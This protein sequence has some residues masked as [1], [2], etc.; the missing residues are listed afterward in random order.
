MGLLRAA[1]VV[2]QRARSNDASTDARVLHG[3]YEAGSAGQLEA[4]QPFSHTP[5]TASFAGCCRWDESLEGNANK[6][7]KVLTLVDM[8]DRDNAPSLR[9]LPI[10]TVPQAADQTD[11]AQ[12][13]FYVMARDQYVPGSATPKAISG[14][15]SNYELD[16][17]MNANLIYSV[18]SASNMGLTSSVYTPFSK[19]QIVSSSTG[20]VRVE[21][22]SSVTGPLPTGYYQVAVLVRSGTS[23]TL[24]DFM[25]HVV[26]LAGLPAAASMSGA[27][28]H[29][30]ES[31]YASTFG[32]VGYPVAASLVVANPDAGDLVLN[33]VFAGLS[34]EATSVQSGGVEYSAVEL[35]HQGLP[36]GASLYT[37]AAGAIVDMLITYD[38][39]STAH[40]PGHDA[41]VNK[42]KRD[43]TFAMG[44]EEAW[45]AGYRPVLKQG[46]S[47]DD[48]NVNAIPDTISHA[49][50][51]MNAGTG[52]AAMYLWLKKS[53]DMPAITEVR[54]A[55][56]P[57]EVT[58]YTNEGFTMLPQNLNEQ[59]SSPSKVYLFYK[60]GSG[61]A[62]TDITLI[63]VQV[64][65]AGFCAGASVTETVCDVEM[66][67]KAM[68]G[69]KHL[70]PGNLNFPLAQ[71]P[72]LMYVEVAPQGSLKRMLSWVP[73]SAGHY[74]FCYSG[75]VVGSPTRAS[76]QRCIDMDIRNDPAPAFQP[77]PPL[78]TKMGKV[79]R[80][81]V[82]Y[83]DINHPDEHVSTE[84]DMQGLV[85]AGATLGPVKVFPR[86]GD[87]RH[88]IVSREVDWFPDPTYGGFSG[89]VCFV[90]TDAEGMYREAAAT[91]GCVTISVDRCV[92]HVQTEDTLIQVAARFATNWLQIWHFNPQILHPDS[93]LP[94]NTEINIGHLYE[95]EPNDAMSVLADRFGT[96]IK[97]IRL[98]NFDL[99]HAA[100]P[101]DNIQVGSSICLIPNSCVTAKHNVP[102]A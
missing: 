78:L 86:P 79:L 90:A 56:C 49:A 72:L 57:S 36:D 68:C 50:F 14:G 40:R 97:H 52:G 31:V 15:T 21:T 16:D 71:R 28:L 8:T 12:P 62:L 37:I 61:P 44:A 98:N 92:W 93:A 17:N 70:V 23:R 7:Y 3:R 47:I 100:A 4:N 94:P 69:S 99:A 45:A 84:M 53:D 65:G 30:E 80:F 42:D 102:T 25:L 66:T 58:K 27:M 82:S 83:V 33:Y 9:S 81:N 74:V 95:V 76:T 1:E 46:S 2:P 18:A 77:L 34:M 87:V 59:S 11:D 32:W 48:I 24:V 26:P 19:F 101:G 13:T 43:F 6:M 51:D 73:R 29:G 38:N 88:V 75:S 60:R 39:P 85:L 55:H 10:V 54:I 35:N 96:S 89:D 63:D 67:A 20:K 91:K 41:A 5:W 22:N 64:D